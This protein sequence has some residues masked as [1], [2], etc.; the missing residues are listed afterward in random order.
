MTYPVAV[1]PPGCQPIAPA[2]LTTGVVG[3]AGAAPTNFAGSRNA[4]VTVHHAAVGIQT[5]FPCQMSSPSATCRTSSISYRQ[6]SADTGVE[7]CSS[8]TWTGLSHT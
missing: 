1:P 2:A 7:I 6:T 5:G 4:L 8:S 3:A